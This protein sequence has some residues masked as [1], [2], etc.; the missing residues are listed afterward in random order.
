MG[1]GM[2]MRVRVVCLCAYARMCVS[3]CQCVCVRTR[4]G[5]WS[6]AWV[7]KHSRK[8]VGEWVFLC[9]LVLYTRAYARLHARPYARQCISAFVDRYARACT[10]IALVRLSCASARLSIDMRARVP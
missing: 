6:R 5:S 9:V 10:V 2:R 4:I 3:A 8:Y 1:S 7:S